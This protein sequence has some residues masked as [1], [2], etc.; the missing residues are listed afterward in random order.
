MKHKEFYTP[1]IDGIIDHYGS[2]DFGTF[3]RQNQNLKSA[4][5]AAILEQ[6]HG[7]LLAIKPRIDGLDCTGSA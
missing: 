5:I 3:H 1:E 6:M 7:S 2:S 4:N